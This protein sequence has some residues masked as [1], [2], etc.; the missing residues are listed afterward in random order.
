MAHHYPKAFTPVLSD[1]ELSPG[2]LRVNG[3]E[4]LG[5]PSPPVQSAAALPDLSS[6]T[7]WVGGT[8][9]AHEAPAPPLLGCLGAL[10]VDREGYDILDTPT[11]HG[12]EARCMTRVSQNL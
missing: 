1:L 7:Y 12:V 8:P 4:T 3:E 5:S 11:R 6:T 2:S 10:S 9:P